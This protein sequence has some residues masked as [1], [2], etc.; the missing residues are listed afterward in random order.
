M[1]LTVLLLITS[2]NLYYDFYHH[3]FSYN[4]PLILKYSIWTKVN[5]NLEMSEINKH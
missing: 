5:D 1:F 4:K 2:L 3:F